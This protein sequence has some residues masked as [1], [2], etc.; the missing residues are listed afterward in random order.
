MGIRSVCRSYVKALTE[1]I[2]RGDAREESCYPALKDFL[3]A[4]AE[5]TGRTDI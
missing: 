5:A 2:S 3:I 4:Y 1:T